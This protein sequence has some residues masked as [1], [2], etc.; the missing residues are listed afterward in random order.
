[1][2]LSKKKQVAKI[3]SLLS[4]SIF[5]DCKSEKERACLLFKKYNQ[6]GEISIRTLCDYCKFDRKGFM[7]MYYRYI[8]IPLDEETKFTYLNPEYSKQLLDYI[9]MKI[10]ENH[11]K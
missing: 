3:K 10:K 1:M 4:L 6:D 7:N 2:K 8:N 11:K 9:Q 5:V